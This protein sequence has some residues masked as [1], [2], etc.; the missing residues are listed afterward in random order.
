[1]GKIFRSKKIQI[2]HFQD[3][4]KTSSWRINFFFKK[5]KNL[6]K[7]FDRKKNHFLSKMIFAHRTEIGFFSHFGPRIFNFGLYFRDLQVNSFACLWTNVEVSCRTHIGFC[8]ILRLCRPAPSAARAQLAS[9]MSDSVSGLSGDVTQAPE[10]Q[11][12]KEG[13][14]TGEQR[15]SL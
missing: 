11:R 15:E 3:D 8:A 9:G 2:L 1:M 7:N 6:E 13:G 5:K 10:R 4:R 12:G 14:G